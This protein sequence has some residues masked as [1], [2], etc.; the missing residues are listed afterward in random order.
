MSE[1]F[2][3][4]ESDA[5]SE[6]RVTVSDEDALQGIRL[7]CPRCRANIDWL[8][9][10]FCGFTMQ[11]KNGIVHS[12]PPDRVAHFARFIEDYE[13]IRAEEGRGSAE[14]DFYLRLPYK[15][16]SGK[17]NR[18]WGI[19]ARSFDYLMKHVLPRNLPHENR[20]ILDIGAGNCW[21]SYR[22]SLRGC[23]PFAVDLLTNGFDG[24]GAAEH[25][26]KHLPAMFPRFQAELARLP[27]QDEQFDAALFNSSFHYSEDYVATL[28]EAIRCVK[29]GGIVIVIDTP[30][31]SGEE[32]GRRMVAERKAAFLQRYGTSSNSIGS[33]EYLTDDRLRTLEEQ[34]PIQWAIHSPRYG[35]KWAL[36]PLVAKLFNLRE[37][38]RFRIYETRKA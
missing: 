26:R 27:F 14:D 38:S 21:L 34:L 37:P 22:L 5:C 28:H 19:R 3:S 9:C 17:N 1:R 15:D 13:R 33:L 24:L 4:A 29:S 12:L 32:S 18:Q 25:F 10:P 2:H 8:G 11:V 30:W 36:R 31:Y 7:Q 16:L 23:R 20:W 6:A 35:L